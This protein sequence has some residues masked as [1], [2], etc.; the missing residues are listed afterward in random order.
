MR[1]FAK[2]SVLLL[3]IKASMK[4]ECKLSC[5]QHFGHDSVKILSEI[6]GRFAV[7]F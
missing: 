5:Y 7:R 1:L 2:V 6:I 3:C 4:I